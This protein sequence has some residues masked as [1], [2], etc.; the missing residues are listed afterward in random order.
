MGFE[1]KQVSS[2]T[3]E[4]PLWQ[5]YRDQFPVTERLIYMNHA[6]VA[7]LPRVAAEAM[8]TWAQDALDFGS[9]HY[10]KWLD[11]YEKLRVA[12]ARLIGAD[13]SE[14]NFGTFAWAQPKRGVAAQAHERGPIAGTAQRNEER[15]SQTELTGFVAD[16]A[17]FGRIIRA[18]QRL[19]PAV[20]E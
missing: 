13:R 2:T 1:Q 18:G 9:L 19:F 14:M 15:R 16:P 20:R 11:T 7:P 17:L 4:L 8:Q 6:A 5:Q 12:A 3:A 10:D